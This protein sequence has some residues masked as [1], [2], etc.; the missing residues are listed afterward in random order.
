M[1][2]SGGGAAKRS[3]RRSVAFQGEAGAF[4]EAAAID[5]FQKIHG[6]EIDSQGH[7]EFGDVFVAVA[8]GAFDFGIVPVENSASGTLHTV[9]DLLLNSSLSIVGECSSIEEHCLCAMPETAVGSLTSVLS[10]PAMFE[11]CSQFLKKLD[12]DRGERLTR[13]AHWDTAAA[14]TVVK[15]GKMAHAAAISSREAATR[16][17]LKILESGIGNDK[18]NETRYL[19]VANKPF[20]LPDSAWHARIKLKCSVAVALQNAPN[21]LFRMVSCFALRNL[22]ILKIESRPA[23]TANATTF[24]GDCAPGSPKRTVKHWDYI[25]YIDYEPS[26]DQAVNDNMLR[27]LKE[28]SVG[29]RSFGTYHQNLPDVVAVHS[30]WHGVA[31]L[32]AC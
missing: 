6:E 8:T 20:E 14:C 21:A 28:F 10:H 25:F 5:H 4:S 19:L 31:E 24:K 13:E 30:P 32:A 12:A 2:G 7:A 17:G 15:E 22:N 26:W 29:V 9:Y 18:N 16:N 23:S 3:K 11:Q 27:A 1:S